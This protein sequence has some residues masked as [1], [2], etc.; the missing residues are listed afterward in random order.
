[1]KNCLKC[2]QRGRQDIT[3][4]RAPYPS[5]FEKKNSKSFLEHGIHIVQRTSTSRCKDGPKGTWEVLLGNSFQFFFGI[6]LFGNERLAPRQFLLVSQ[7]AHFKFPV[8]FMDSLI[9][10]YV[11]RAFCRAFF[12]LMDLRCRKLSS[13]FSPVRNMLSSLVQAILK[14]VNF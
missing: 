2:C 8:L 3:S 6:S 7:L 1:M 12:F 5:E 9:S 10:S 13:P 14:L 4:K 11:T